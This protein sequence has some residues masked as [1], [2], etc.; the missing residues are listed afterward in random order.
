MR[1]EGA[2][3]RNDAKL[4]ADNISGE[5][6]M[7]MRRSEDFPENFS[8][9]LIY[10]SAD[11]RGDIT[12]LRCNGKHGEYNGNFD[13]DHPHYDYHIH[14]AEEEAITLGYRAEKYAKKTTHFAS[15]EEALQFFIKTI[16]LNAEDA[17]KYFASSAQAQL[18][19]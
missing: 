13:P 6:R 10:H 1:I 15:Y 14:K 19:F 7:F 9:G 2:H 4:L 16:N 12:L 11:D 8:V 18:P 3:A 17:K 5:F